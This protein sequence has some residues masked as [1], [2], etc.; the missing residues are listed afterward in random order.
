MANQAKALVNSTL[1]SADDD[2]FMEHFRY[3]IIAS[4][5]LNDHVGPTSSEA[6]Y[7]LESPST[8]LF[9]SI[10]ATSGGALTVAIAS[11]TSAWLVHW[12]RGGEEPT[13]HLDRIC[14]SLIVC[15]IL[16]L[17]LYAYATRQCFQRIR[18]EAIQ[19]TSKF[20]LCIQGLE[21]AS[22][23]V[24]SMIQEVEVISRGYRM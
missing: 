9:P 22:T 12:V 21:R 20:V 5:L 2:R 13:L 16:A 10:S 6:P 17:T 14:I 1:G 24:L 18:H 8:T 15:A 3:I 4:Q 11:F 19:A 7:N 23:S